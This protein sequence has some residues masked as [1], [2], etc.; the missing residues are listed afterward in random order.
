[1][2]FRC[3]LCGLK[4]PNECRESFLFL[5]DPVPSPAPGKNLK[6]DRPG[7][8]GLRGFLP[9]PTDRFRT[10]YPPSRAKDFPSGDAMDSAVFRA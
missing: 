6:E 8:P 9:I 2:I 10:G 7:F 1:M 4:T 5:N 3:M